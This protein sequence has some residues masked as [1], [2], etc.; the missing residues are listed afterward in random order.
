MDKKSKT[1]APSTS[2]SSKHTSG[3]SK[4][5]VEP[6]P[7]R[8]SPEP[9]LGEGSGDEPLRSRDSQITSSKSSHKE[10]WD[11][12]S[13]QNSS[14]D[15]VEERR[16]RQSRSERRGGSD[17]SNRSY[18]PALS[19]T[20]DPNLEGAL[21]DFM[22]ASVS[23]EE[24]ERLPKEIRAFMRTWSGSSSR[25]EDEANVMTSWS[26]KPPSPIL[27]DRGLSCEPAPIPPGLLLRPFTQRLD[28]SSDAEALAY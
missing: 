28:R 22:T 16:E 14:S 1:Q 24:V 8:S 21:P 10:S 7:L 9:I 27:S 17:D 25:P 3:I 20:L 26:T 15:A 13:D 12:P 2:K 4:P 5:R 18:F 19:G 6:R 11:W 23:A